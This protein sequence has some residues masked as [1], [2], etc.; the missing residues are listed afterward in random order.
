VR[1]RRGDY[2]DVMRV[3]QRPPLVAPGRSADSLYGSPAESERG[4]GIAERRRAELES[5]V[6]RFAPTLILPAGDYVESEGRRFRCLPT[7]P[8][9]FADTLRLDLIRPAPYQFYE[10]RDIPWRDLSH[11]SLVTLTQAALRYES[12]PTSLVS[13]YFDFPGR[14]PSEWW[15]AYARLRSGPDSARWAEPTVFAHPFF[16]GENRLIIQYW[17]FYPFNDYLGNHEGDWEH[18]NVVP[19]ADGSRVAEVHYYFHQRSVRLPQGSR[20]PRIAD[21]THVLVYVGGRGYNVLDYPIRWIAHERNE[22][23][24]GNYPFPGEWEGAAGLGAPESV[25]GEN[26]DSTRVLA[27][28]RFR[29]V[30][31]PEPSRID[32]RRRDGLAAWAWLLLPVRWGSPTAPSLGSGLKGDVGNHAP[33]GP[34]YDASWD[35]TAPGLLYPV[36]RVRQ[37]PRLRGYV[38]DLLQPWYYLYAFRSPRFVSDTRG[39]LQR[40]ELVRLGLMPRGGGAERG[41][42]STILGAHLAYPQDAQRTMYR[43]SS[44][45]SLSKGFWSKARFGAVEIVGGYQKFRRQDRQGSVFVYPLT[46]HLVARAPEALFRPYV[47][48]GTGAFGWE[49]RFRVAADTQLVSS[50]WNIGYSAGVGVEYYLRPRVALDVAVRYQRSADIGGIAGQSGVPLRL[51]TVWIGH[52]VRF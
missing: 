4:D 13:A 37:V 45:F 43:T 38:E 3:D 50:G 41:L 33:Y 6:R 32:S 11:D 9:L 34:A 30:L 12:D 46:I 49:T 8:Q 51:V 16:D 20:Q 52:Y 39:S 26:G 5:L 31:T 28:D 47:T 44:S 21:G 40:A 42:G 14:S 19:T 36:F 7:D 24:H 17:Y 23:P 2:I 35:R 25:Q 22:G 27:H 18:L 10:G 15:S 29:V 48:A 1:A